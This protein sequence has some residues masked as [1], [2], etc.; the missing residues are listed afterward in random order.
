MKTKLVSALLLATVALACAS[1]ALASK[2]SDA[3]KA[4]VTLEQARKT[5]LRAVPNAKVKAEELEREHGKLV[6]SFDLQVP[7]KP[8]I[9]EVQVDAMSGKVV[10]HQHE[11]AEQE[12]KEQEQE[13]QEHQGSH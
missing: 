2:S 12:R 9:E 8:G 3:A 10:S 5:A 4:K 6:Y 1:P 7:G 13:K 11:S